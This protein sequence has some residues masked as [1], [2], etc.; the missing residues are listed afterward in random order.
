M[1]KINE[2]EI[3]KAIEKIRSYGVSPLDGIYLV[4]VDIDGDLRIA[5]MGFLDKI[6]YDAGGFIANN[7][8]KIKDLI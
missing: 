3:K 8:V 1:I 6:F 2:E 5:P 4:A 7:F